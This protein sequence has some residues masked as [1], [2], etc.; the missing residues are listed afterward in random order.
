MYSWIYQFSDYKD[1]FEFLLDIAI[2]KNAEVHQ[3]EIFHNMAKNLVLKERV[4]KTGAYGFLEKRFYFLST[5]FLL[6]I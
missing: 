2:I 1:H 5:V 6:E 3:N 4:P